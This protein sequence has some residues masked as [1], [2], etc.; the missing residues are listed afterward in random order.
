[1]LS[2]WGLVVFLAKRCRLL[3]DEA[4]GSVLKPPFQEAIETWTLGVV[5]VGSE[6][7]LGFRVQKYVTSASSWS[8]QLL[9]RAGYFVTLQ[10]YKGP[11]TQTVYT[12]A[13]KVVPIQVLW[14]QGLYIR[15]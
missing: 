10:C 4:R 14:S 7:G 3:N 2:V 15:L 5:E 1:M 11:C 13:L 6:E 9:Q 12:L 8:L